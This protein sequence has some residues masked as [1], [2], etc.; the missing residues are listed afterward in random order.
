VS[1][2]KD[3]FFW[4]VLGS[5]AACALA[6]GLLL[7]VHEAP[8]E[9]NHY[10]YIC[11]LKKE[12]RLPQQLPLPPEVAGE[13]HQPPLYYLLG[14][15]ALRVLDPSAAWVE[16]PGNPHPAFNQDPAWFLH[17]AEEGLLS[18]KGYARGPHL[19]RAAQLWMPLFS[20]A[21]LWMLL[22][23]LPLG[24]PAARGAFA[25]M[26]LNPGFCFLSGALNNDHLVILCFS[27]CV[28]A[29]HD[30]SK[31]GEWGWGHSLACGAFLGLGAL[32]KLSIFCLFPLAFLLAWRLGGF[33]RAALCL[34]L[35][36]ALCGAFYARNLRLYGELFG[37]KMH[38]LTCPNTV[39]PK[40]WN[41]WGW[42][43]FWVKRSFESFWIIFGWLT[44]S[45]PRLW[46]ALF[47]GLCLAGLGGLLGMRW[48]REAFLLALALLG[49]TAGV[50]KFGW[51]FDPPE[52]RYFYPALL[53]IGALL[54]LGWQR[55]GAA[56]LRLF[57][58]LLAG[59]LFLLNAWVLVARALPLYYRVNP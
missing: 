54:A 57:P 46:N 44:F 23:S 43:C 4:A 26:A 7:P 12:G 13:G 33:K 6:W 14:A 37:W 34:G 29:M 41:D 24:K 51:A 38:E 5:F 42:L 8:D 32:S 58:L 17:F 3:G 19:L 1:A 15:S 20:L 48:S 56:R 50:A 21:M 22:S 39:H 30:A 9:Q 27:A 52:G 28:L 45:A 55:L 31:Q 53:P 18:F 25:L 2:F 49:L 16:L 59:T 35:A 36:V 10:R 40:R 11:F 47:L